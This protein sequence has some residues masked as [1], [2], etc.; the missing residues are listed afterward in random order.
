M[1]D[2][3]QGL[4]ESKVQIFS[5]SLSNFQFQSEMLRT[6]KTLLR[7]RTVL[8]ECIQIRSITFDLLHDKS[9]VDGK[10]VAAKSGATF[11]VTNPS[12]NKVLGNVPD[13][14][15][16]DA[17][18]AVEVAH[19]AFQTWKNTVAKERGFLL[20]SWHNKIM[21][22]QEALAKLLTAEMGKPVSEARTEIAYGASFVEWFAE[23][24]RRIYGDTI[25]SP[26]ATKRFVTIK[27]PVGVAGMITPWNFPNAMITRKA[28]AALAAGC[29]V[30][31]KPSEDTPYSA[32]ALCELAE[33]A[34]FP[35]GV[36][37]VI[38]SSREKTPAVGK[39]L[40][41]HP[42]VSKISFTGSTAVGKILL[43]QS[44]GTVKRVS[45][46]LGGNAAFIVFDSA[47]VDAAVAGA[48]ASKFRTSGQTCVCSNRILVQEGVHDR[49]VQAFANA[50][51]Q[52]K[53][54]DGFEDG[55]TQGPLINSSAVKKVEDHVRDAVSKGAAIVSGGKR[56]GTNSNFFEPTVITGV[57]QDMLCSREETFGPLAPII[58]FKTE[59]EAIAIANSTSSGLAGYFFSGNVSQVW[60]VAERLQV[61]M[62][63]IN[64]GILSS[65][66]A[67]FGGVKE[68]G[69]GREGSKYGIDEYLQIKY[70]CFGGI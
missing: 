31:L 16:E 18:Q 11:K 48:M 7:Q 29:T 49:F 13:M 33:K 10:W 53:L 57:K 44:A 12:D 65:V 54:G 32:L 63:G 58:K 2:E 46:E 60:R 43:S 17:G 24:A 30:V 25:P 15:A 36:L 34:G 19:K 41:Q 5:L 23:E 56:L 42:L 68:S 52:L 55:V 37:N 6:A 69:I 26:F 39:L 35:S 45:M 62:V 20:R 61:G 59:E 3:S 4:D 67:P 50:V 64:E 8:S 22:N 27:Q 14:D 9:Y 40:C 47:N 38:T 1:S 21:E 66:E 51:K 28:S 70:L